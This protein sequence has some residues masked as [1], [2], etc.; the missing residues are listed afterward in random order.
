[1]TTSTTKKRYGVIGGELRQNTVEAIRH[2]VPF[3]TSGS[4]KA[5]A[6]P[7]DVGR[8]PKME[9]ERFYRDRASI[10]YAVISY[11]TPIAW[12]C[13]DS[14]TWFIVEER[15]SKTTQRHQALVRQAVLTGNPTPAPYRV[16][17]SS[18]LN[19]WLELF[20][21]EGQRPGGQSND[22]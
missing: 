20:Y 6:H 2:R 3:K 5:T 17:H 16:V 7:T 8:L 11:S 9:R 21:A 22:R 13:D 14:A 15:F 18:G 1:M 10:T 4:L 12:F 19:S